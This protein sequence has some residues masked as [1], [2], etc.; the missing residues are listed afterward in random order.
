MK[1]SEIMTRD[2]RHCLTTDSL[3][4][5]AQIMW[6]HD[7]GALPVLDAGGHTVAMVTDRDTCMAAYTQGKPLREIPVMTAASHC[8][9]SVRPEDPIEIAQSV[10]RM[11]RVRRVPVIDFGGNLVGIVTLVDLLRRAGSSLALG[12]PIDVDAVGT[13]LTAVFRADDSRA[14]GTGAE[15]PRAAHP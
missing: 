14:L 8:V 13:M 2:V 3:E 6:E 1:V 9:H 12:S 15:E 10:M 4:R 11:H 5:A 7:L